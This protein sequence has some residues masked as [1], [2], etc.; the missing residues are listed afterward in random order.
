MSEFQTIKITRIHESE[1]NPRRRYSDLKMQEL[2]LSVK[3]NGILNPLLVRPID[4]RPPAEKD[5]EEFGLLSKSGTADFEILAGSRRYRAAIAAE[6]LEVPCIVKDVNDDEALEIQLFENDQ[7]EDVHPLEQA[8][9]YK[10]WMDR[11]RHTVSALAE[12]LGCS[13]T[14]IY[15]RLK[16][17][18]LTPAI[19]A[20]FLEEK[21]TAEHAAF[22]SRLQPKDQPKAFEYCFDFDGVSL[23]SAQR[24]RDWIDQ[25][26]HLDLKDAPF[27]TS[28]EDLL[29]EAG[30]CISCPKRTGFN[31][32]LFSDIQKEDTCT[33]GACFRRKTQAHINRE[34]ARQEEKG[35]QILKVSSE[36]GRGKEKEGAPLPASKY[37]RISS[38]D[39]TCEHTQKAIVVAGRYDKGKTINVCAN[40]D[41]KVHKNRRFSSGHDPD[42]F[43]REEKAREEKAAKEQGIRVRILDAILAKAREL[44][45]S[46]ADWQLIATTLIERIPRSR[47]LL[48]RRHGWIGQK[49]EFVDDSVM[50]KEMLKLDVEDLTTLL[51]EI[52]I[53]NHC[54]VDPYDQMKRPQ[55][56]LHQAERFGVS[57]KAIEKGLDR[58]AAPDKS[59]PEKKSAKTGK[60]ETKAGKKKTKGSKP[61]TAKGSRK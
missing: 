23:R 24:L 25:T 2:I 55:E 3:A 20:A 18:D 5:L 37:N 22:I 12:K 59:A 44:P 42:Q 29:P 57:I 54:V 30:S 40:P 45:W 56:L 21:I 11:P 27:K 15:K 13:D 7:R 38:K 51:I 8:I 17:L 32:L 60:S 34:I 46:L 35:K 47:V 61:K 49:V 9:G 50:I 48:S 39:E 26:I 31:T 4:L 53:S 58:P 33:D 1:N 10:Q 6:L 19:Q 14:H 52:C 41:C 28:D 36:Y 43:A 16:L